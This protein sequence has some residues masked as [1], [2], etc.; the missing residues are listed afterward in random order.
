MCRRHRCDAATQLPQGSL[1]NTGFVID[2]KIVGAGLPAMAG[3][4]ATR[5]LDVLA[6]SPAGQLPQLICARR[7]SHEQPHTL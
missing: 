5:M 4:L 2:T 3:Y 7:E 1:A 6:S